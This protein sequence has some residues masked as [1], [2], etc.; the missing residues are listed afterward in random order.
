MKR[1]GNIS[2]MLFLAVTAAVGEY[3]YYDSFAR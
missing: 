1:R 3:K 2:Y